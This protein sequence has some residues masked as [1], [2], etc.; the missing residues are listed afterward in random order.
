MTKE[1]AKILAQII[2]DNLEGGYYHPDM[3]PKLKN[4]YK[5]GDSG[6]TMFGLDRVK[7]NIENTQAGKDFFKKVDEYYMQH[8]ADTNYYND[9]AD[10]THADI[11]ASVGTV[12]KDLAAEV[13]LTRFN[14]YAAKLDSAAKEVVLND[15][16]LLIQFFYAVYNGAGKFE[17]FVN[18]INAAYSQGTQDAKTLYNLLQKERRSWGTTETAKEL[19]NKGADKL[20]KIIKNY[21]NLDYEIFTPAPKSK[22]SSNGWLW[23]ILGGA[24]LWL[25]MRNNK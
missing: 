1:D 20:N 12:L 13:I 14:T 6:E 17:K 5:M 4:G 9:K 8:H 11:P 21:Y 7:G 25:I 3:K 24:A 15:P 18:V 19:Y 10:G 22:K 16:A 23:L 2:I